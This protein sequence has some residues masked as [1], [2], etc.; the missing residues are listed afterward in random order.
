MDKRIH[1]IWEAVKSLERA[2]IDSAAMCYSIVDLMIDQGIVT[3]E[4]FARQ[5]AKSVAKVVSVHKQIAEAM[6]EKY[7]DTGADDSRITVH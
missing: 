7:P 1:D 5:M 4:E 2:D 3:R 6:R